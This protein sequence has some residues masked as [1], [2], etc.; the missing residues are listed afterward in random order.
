M[1]F[2]VI[3]AGGSG[4]RFWPRSRKHSPK[5][6]LE[7][8][9]NKTP[10]EETF[11]RVSGIIPRERIYVITAKAQAR[12]TSFQLHAAAAENIIAE[13]RGCDTAAAVGLSALMISKKDPDAVLVVL[14]SDHLIRP[15]ER[16]HETISA[17]AKLVDETD[18]L[19]TF[20]VK[21]K[22]PATGYGYI[23]RSEKTGESNGIPAY[24]VAD[25]REKPDDERA[26]EYVKSGEYYWNSGI[27]MWRASTILAEIEKHVPAL[28]DGLVNIKEYL[29]SET[30]DLVIRDAYEKF[31]RI[32]ID[33]AVMEK[34][35][36]VM[37]LE[38]DY[39]W[40]D[41]GSWEALERINRKDAHGNV[42]LGA[43]L[44]IETE[45]CIV[46]GD[47]R[48]IIATVGVKDLIIVSTSTATLVCRK[49]DSE[50]VKEI[51][52]RLREEGLE[53]YL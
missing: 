8:I 1:L 14:P 15:D 33:Y 39:E 12:A 31:E 22:G 34:A 43:N 46:F 48:H 49:S 53:S 9:R 28:H 25:F 45:D 10:I 42:I 50:R 40:D 26:R 51:V 6:L 44:G 21:P 35:D 47:P 13:P 29:G 19:L 5:Q 30:Q 41:I 52:E 7:I 18:C 20:G 27:F 17:G 38:T 36:N 24:R 11:N 23:R 32:S 2:A 3:L 16:F 4:T 37:V